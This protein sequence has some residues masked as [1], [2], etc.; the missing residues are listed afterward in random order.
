MAQHRQLRKEARLDL[1]ARRESIRRT[2]AVDQE[3]D[4]LEPGLERRPDQIFALTT[5]EAQP[6][7]LTA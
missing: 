4:R 6:L 7:T 2:L 3:V 1:S 5:E